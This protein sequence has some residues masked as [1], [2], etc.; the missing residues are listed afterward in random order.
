M[1]FNITYFLMQRSKQ[2]LNINA[3]Q[4]QG[5]NH[6]L[7]GSIKLHTFRIILD[8]TPR[9]D[10]SNF[11]TMPVGFEIRICARMMTIHAFA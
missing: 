5:Q 7:L 6:I 2:N 1:Q 10:D 8:F 9:G 4:S 3:L 11:G